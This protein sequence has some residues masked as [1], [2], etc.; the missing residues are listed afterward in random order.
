M[1]RVK[2]RIFAGAVC[3]QEVYTIA[4][5]ANVKKSECRPRFKTEEEREQHK[6]A[7]SRRNHARLFNENF[8]PSSLY[9]T[10]TFDRENECHGKEECKILRDLYIRRLKYAFPNAVI[11]S[12]YGEGKNTH[13][14]HIHMVSE[15]IPEEV[16][17]KQWTY[18]DVT[19]IEHIREHC[20]YDGR[21]H[22]RD[23]TGLANYLF[24]HWRKSYGGHRW[25]MT[26]NARRPEREDATEIKRAYSESKPPRAPKGYIYIESKSNEYGYLYFKYV[27]AE[28]VK[29]HPPRGGTAQSDA[30]E[31][32]RL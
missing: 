21:D 26:R 16:I 31:E 22:G 12:Y 20:Y 32:R 1:K 9:S 17:K 3:E 23:Y 29:A 10:L 2:R 14:F 8:S 28:F 5:R 13:R 18:G 7:I 24:D 15:G 27:K 11:F 4:D 6:D 30:G 19:R 25:K